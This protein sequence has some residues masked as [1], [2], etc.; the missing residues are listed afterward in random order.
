MTGLYNVSNALAAIS[1]ALLLEV[2]PTD[3]KRAL[4][5]F[6]GVK[7]RLQPIQNNRGINAYVDFAHTPN[8]LREVLSNLKNKLNK[9]EKLIVVFGSAGLRDVSKRPLMGKYA[10]QFADQIIITSEDPRTED[11]K[12]IVKD[13]MSG[14]P[15]GARRKVVVELDRGVAIDRAINEFAQPGDWVVSCGKGHET[16]MNLDGWSETPWSDQKAMEDAL[17]KKINN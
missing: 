15:S 17:N 2:H 8:A 14:I 7:G 16:S 13:I 4:L 11:P 12:D 5:S 10:A 1:T 3:I 6:P 9:T